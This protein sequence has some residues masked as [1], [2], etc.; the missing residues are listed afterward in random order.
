VKEALQ[1]ETVAYDNECLATNRVCHDLRVPQPLEM[2]S[3]AAH[4]T[5]VNDHV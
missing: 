4:I 5:L 1:M 3:L 2:S